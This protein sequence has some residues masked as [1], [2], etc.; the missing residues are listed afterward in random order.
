M[1][2]LKQLVL[3]TA[4]GLVG[5]FLAVAGATTARGEPGPDFAAA[6]SAAHSTEAAQ[7]LNKVAG[8]TATAKSAAGSK[9][10]IQQDT[11]PVYALSADFVRTKTGDVGT[12]WYVATPAAK[13]STQLTVFTAPDQ[14]GAWHPVNVATG[15]TEAK[16][17]ASARGAKLL[18]EPQIG[19]WYAVTGNTLRALN[20]EATKA[21]GSSPITLKAYGQL[22]NTRYADKQAD[23]TYNENGTA[24]GYDAT[25]TA[26]TSTAAASQSNI[27]LILAGGTVI[28]VALGTT[29]LITR[30]RHI[31]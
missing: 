4:A 1:K 2:P 29:T 7:L 26:G 12:L 8:R 3:R 31:A 11:I 6:K 13:G 30:R 16:L 21:I 17:A 23:S 22:V 19:A 9:L 24:G 18:T 25:A 5:A 14:A 20:P 28:A 27:W 15:N 10:A